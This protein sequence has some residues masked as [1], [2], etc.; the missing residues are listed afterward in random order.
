VPDNGDKFQHVP[1]EKVSV[2]EEL[3]GHVAEGTDR[4]S[5]IA[6]IASFVKGTEN[7]FEG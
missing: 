1:V 6:M 4:L 2:V 3:F 7:I 5:W